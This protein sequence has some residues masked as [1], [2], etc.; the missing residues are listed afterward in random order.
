LSGSGCWELVDPFISC[1][2]KIAG[3][4][5]D[6]QVQEL[7]RIVW[8]QLNAVYPRK[9]WLITVNNLNPKVIKEKSRNLLQIFI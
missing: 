3:S 2:H 7:Y 4:Q 9:L 5:V 8:M 1:I 6:R